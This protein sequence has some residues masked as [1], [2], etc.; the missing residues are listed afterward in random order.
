ML[1]WLAKPH[2]NHIKYAHFARPTLV[3]RAAYVRRYILF[4]IEGCD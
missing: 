4:D 1:F 2:N 3:P